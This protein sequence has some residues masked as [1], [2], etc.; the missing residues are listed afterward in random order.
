MLHLE[1]RDEQLDPFRLIL[2]LS[3]G[4]LSK[5]TWLAKCRELGVENIPLVDTP[6][7]VNERGIVSAIRAVQ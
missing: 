2:R 4:D 7:D 1:H 3:D 6:R 5:E